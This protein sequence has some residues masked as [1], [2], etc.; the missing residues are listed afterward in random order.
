MINIEGQLEHIIYHNPSNH[1]TVARLRVR[2]T[3]SL[4]SITG[5]MPNPTIGENLTIH[6]QWQSHPKYGQQLQIQSFESVLP[7]SINGIRTYLTSGAVKGVG[8]KTAK[9]IIEQFGSQTLHIIEN[10]PHKLIQIKGIGLKT[11][12]TIA[13]DWKKNQVARQLMTFLQANGIQPAYSARI[14]KAYGTD[15][16]SVLKDEPYRLVSDLADIGFIIADTLA[17]NQGLA[18]DDPHRVKACLLYLMDQT[19]ADG[20]LWQE[21]DRLQQTCFEQFHIDPEQTA[22]MLNQMVDHQELVRHQFE[23]PV[24]STV[25]YPPL[26]YEAETAIARRL[27]AMQTVP[28][29]FPAIA[30]KFIDDHI[31]NQMAIQLSPPQ[32]NILVNLLHHRVAVITGGPG[33]GKTTLIRAITVLFEKLGCKTVLATPT[34]RAA[35]RLAQVTNR[36]TFTLHRL[37]GF[38]FA[39]GYFEYDENNPLSADVIII[40]EASMMDALLTYYLVKAVRLKAVLIFVG[41]VFQ[42]PPVGPGNILAD[43]IK[44][45]LIPIFELSQIFRQASESNIIVNA[46]RIRNGE[47]LQFD[48]AAQQNNLPEFYFI[49]DSDPNNAAKHVVEICI[50]QISSQHNLHPVYDIQ[51]LTPMH[52][53]AVGT[54]N[55]NHLMQA[56]LNPRG[57][58]PTSKSR[59]RTGDKVMHLKNNYQKEVFNG[60]IGIVQT[61]DGDKSELSVDYDGRMVFYE[62]D[63]LEELSLAYAISVHKSQGSEYPA[64]IMPLT[65]QHYPLLQRNLLYT[66]ITRAK[67]VAVLIG[68]PKALEIALTNDK[69]H[70]RQTGLAQFLQSNIAA[71]K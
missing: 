24:S 28:M 8:S 37:L 15:A 27:H 40:D 2:S 66:A 71:S 57:S 25:I 16:L 56:T 10:D 19:V 3:H 34:G 64:V 21:E 69:P 61:V 58:T 23:A 43:M 32:M 51:V 7:S 44:S 31:L 35:R 14:L 22:D 1:F 5:T 42:L 67:K 52:R 65:T 6:G 59:F 12:E 39:S 38:N 55:L 53:G 60:D 33:T 50:Q 68:S 30:T 41:D 45:G 70:Q 48:D 46:H 11:A 20:N 54:I 49:Q 63:E 4:I 13:Q 62:F 18:S 47:S 29:K 9:R 36:K 17:Q 26:L